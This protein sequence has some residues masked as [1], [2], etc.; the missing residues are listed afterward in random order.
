MITAN[1]NKTKA[2]SNRKTI[3]NKKEKILLLKIKD[4]QL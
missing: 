2:V 1:Q 3:K 4:V